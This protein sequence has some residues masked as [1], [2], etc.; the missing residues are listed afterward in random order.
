MAVEPGGLAADGDPERV[1]QVLANLV[2]NAIRHSPPGGRV[3]VS[4]RRTGA[5]AAFEVADEGPGIAPEERARV[6]E[7]F[8]RGPS[9]DEE[10]RDGAGL[11]LALVKELAE[12]MGGRVRASNGPGGGARFVVELPPADG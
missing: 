11:G 10:R 3:S 5:G 6:F 9:A 12:A 8:Y 2:A 7:R 1:H 4:A